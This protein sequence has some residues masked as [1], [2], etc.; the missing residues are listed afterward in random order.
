VG[1]KSVTRTIYKNARLL[2]PVSDLDA[3][4]ALLVE[5]G[6]VVEA[7]PGVFIDAVQEDVDVVDCMGKCLAP[8]LVDMRVTTGE[9]GNEHLETLATASQA[10]AAGGVT[11]I[12]CLPNTDPIVDDVALLEFVERRGAEVGLIS[13]HSYAAATK[14]TRGEEMSE[15]G[16][17]H[18]AGALGFTDGPK[19]IANPL[20]MRRLLSYSTV[21][22]TLVIQHP[23][24]PE[25]VGEGVM[26]EGETA[27]RLGLA[28]IPAAAEVMMI[29]RDL[30]LLALSG[31][32]YHASRVTTSAAIEVI[33]KAKA[34]GLNVTCDTA[35]H[36]FALN[37]GAVTDYRT[38]AKVS[39]PLRS[40]EDR[41]AVL[42]G[43]ANGTIDA[44]ASDHTPRDQDSKRLPFHQAEYGVVGLETLLSVTL[45]SVHNGALSM[46]EAVQA[47]TVGPAKIL[48]LPG[49]RLSKGAPA[50]LVIFD[51]DIAGVIEPAKFRGKS[52]NSPFEGKPIQ[53]RVLKTIRGGRIVYDH[54]VETA[55]E[56]GRLVHA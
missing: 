52:K 10:A 27:T 9:P 16:L 50:D 21:F 33:A 36:Y 37:E 43:L 4:G 53:G 32:R 30:R 14:R 11:T 1:E 7:G 48:G 39:P 35:P 31:G 18:Q 46:L 47:L 45:E 5:D 42:E 51:P 13:V 44:I 25:L 23:E 54:D 15:V 20:V 19:A 22:D 8:G 56:R 3:M 34:D 40:E 29:E 28:G 41:R 49:G 2:D 6:H 38:F 24:I 55:P 26:N 12:V 17:L